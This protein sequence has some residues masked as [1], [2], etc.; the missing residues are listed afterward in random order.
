MR[1]GIN[2]MAWSATVGPAERA[3][4]PVLAAL[5]YEGVELPLFHPA[6]FDPAPVREALQASGLE[7]TL[8][9][10]LPVGASL[11]VP[12]AQPAA[13]AFLRQCLGV[14]RA[15]G[16]SVLCGPLY[17]PVGVRTGAPPT[18][19][20]WRAAV[21]G[22]RV[23]AALAAEAG[24]VVALEP[25]NRFETHFLNTAAQACRLVAEVGSPWLGV[26]LDTFHLNIEEKSLAGALREAGA[27]L[28]HVHLSENDRGIVGSGHLPWGEV[29]AALRAVGYRGWLVCETFN[30]Q[31][32]EIA[33]ATAIWR[34][35]FPDPLTYARES[36]AF[37]R[38]L[39]PTAGGA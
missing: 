2:L 5:G 28:R 33:A 1:L 14:A 22:L 7:C 8:S 4:F 29:L 3:L 27:W 10:A 20:E 15:L 23:V 21:E 35:L 12:D 19:A 13:L 18:A 11:L 31:I 26:H 25:L 34:P 17:A 36:L 30:G 39:L 9:S 32:P 6:A 38:R 37:L 16:A 24:V